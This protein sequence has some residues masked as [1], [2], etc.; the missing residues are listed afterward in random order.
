MKLALALAAPLLALVAVTVIEV[1]NASRRADEMRDQAALASIALG[2]TGLLSDLEW[3]RNAAGIALLGLQDQFTVE[4]EDPE[5]AAVATDAAIEDFRAEVGRQGPSVEEAY[6][7]AFAA[8]D[9]LDELRADVAAVPPED[10]TIASIAEVSEIFDRYTEMWEA[11]AAANRQVVAAIDDAQL[12]QAGQ[13]IDLNNRQT[14]LVAMLVRDVLKAEVGDGESGFSSPEEIEPVGR[15]LYQ[16]RQNWEQMVSLGTGIYA[17]LVEDLLA[18]EEVQQFPQVIA[19]ALDSGR[20]DLSALV[21][22]AANDDPD[23]LAYTVFA[24]EVEDLAADRAATLQDSAIRRQ[25][26]FVVLAVATVVLAALAIWLVSRSITRPLRS[27]TRQAK[28]MADERLPDAVLDIL[29]TPLG[30]DVRVPEVAPV[31]VPTRDEVADVAVALNTV[32]DT[33]L[34][35][36]V[37]QAVLRR[38]IADSFVN[39]GRRNQNLL[40]RQLDFITEL[41]TN[42]TDPDTL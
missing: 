21:R 39:L 20:I 12:R 2:P 18:A 36:A 35:L 13:L 22:Y 14:N 40:G 31:R 4:V 19:T 10:R 32:Q 9:E 8:F 25:R 24:R 41:E 5:T 3:E 38:N 27:L 37:E 42:E 29:E 11:F 33:A 23:T 28:E 7:P 15:R 6:A 26:V 30:D 16:L 1:L 34:D 17:P